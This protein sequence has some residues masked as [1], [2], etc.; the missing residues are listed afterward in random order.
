M[1]DLLS[2]YRAQSAKGNVSLKDEVRLQSLVIQLN[3]DKLGI[4]KNILEF[5]Q[6]LKVLTGI[7][8]DIE[9]QLSDADAKEILAAQ[10]FGMRMN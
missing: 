9:P 3:N 2:A 8:D 4:N 10:P 6:S 5:E 1:N 7:S